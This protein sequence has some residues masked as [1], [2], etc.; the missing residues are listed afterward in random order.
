MIEL[1]H[2]HKN[3]GATVAVADV[4]LAVKRGESVALLGHSGS[5]KTTLLRLVAGLDLPDSGT[6]CVEGRIGMVFQSLALWPHAMVQE[7]IELVLHGPR[8]SGAAKT[9]RVAEMLDVFGLD[10]WA[11]RKP[12]TLSGGE[13]QRVAL[14]RAV[15]SDPEILLL[16]EPLAHLD[17]GSRQELRE[18][19]LPI[20]KGRAVLIAT[21][22][23]EDARVLAQRCLRMREGRIV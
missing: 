7:Q 23:E 3:H 17:G 19:L 12:G 4:S 14:A 22:D 10:S 15:A 1:H 20:L 6:V 9:A 16:D 2:I 18:R 21:H 11:C 13:Q 8:W 5:G